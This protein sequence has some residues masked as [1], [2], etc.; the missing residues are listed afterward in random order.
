MLNRQNK[1]I[2]PNVAPNEFTADGAWHLVWNQKHPEYI[3]R[4]VDVKTF[5]NSPLYMNA[6]NECWEVIKD[7]LKD[8]FQGYDDPEGNWFYN[9]AVFDEGIG[10]GKSYKSSVIITYMIYRT[11][12]LR[13]PYKYLHLAKGSS[14]YFINMSI[15]SGQAR[16]VVFGEIAQRINNSP[17]FR[18]RGFLPDPKVLSELRLPKNIVVIPGNSKETF[19]LGFN[20]LG[21]VMDEAAYYTDTEDHDVAEEMFNALYNRI[22]NRFGRKGMLVMISSPRYVDDFIEKK[23]EEAKTNNKIFTRRRTSWESKPKSLFSGETFV[24]EGFT[25]PIEFE[26]EAN[27]NWERFKRDIMAIP[28]LVLEPYFKQW[29]LVEAGV[30]PSIPNPLNKEGRI[31]ADLQGKKG[32]MY[33]I[34]IDLSLVSDATGVA[35]CHMDG[36]KIYV[37]LMMQIKAEKGRE[38]DL[39][40]ITGIV[41]GLKGMGF[42]IVKVTYDQFQSASSIQELN[43]HGFNASKLSV[44]RDL[45]PYE[46]LKEGIYTG[47]V[48]YYRY[49]P[50][51]MEL[52][53][54]ELIN[55][56]KVDHPN[57]G[58]KDVA[59]ALAG[60]VFNCVTN[61]NNFK[62]WVAGGTRAEQT[63]EEIKKDMETKTAD[64][65]VPYGHYRG[66]RR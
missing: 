2:I 32:K 24:M 41:Y 65:L 52:R 17:W 50:A 45:G 56:K 47:T 11:L 59:D 31:R 51:M 55:G 49:E 30:D 37:D 19:P 34:H 33:Y 46:T 43:K 16:K 64:G 54:L 60:A 23:M 9:E 27:R 26:T 5:I 22:K 7:D 25:I 18:S 14:I 61:Q 58:S 53:R 4:P 1:N 21:G 57:N 12:C 3:E 13:D 8:L 40:E 20:L 38:I 48:K 35:M 15:R 62:F 63:P 36:G 10:A 6:E 44:D 66:R 29:A 39:A 28:S 42:D